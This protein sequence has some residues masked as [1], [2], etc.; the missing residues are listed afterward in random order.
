MSIK[1]D[2][3]LSEEALQIGADLR[4]EYKQIFNYLKDVNA[5][6]HQFLQEVA[7]D[8]QDGKAVFA[9]AFFARALTAF[10][11]L[12]ALAERGFL[13]ECRVIC[14]NLFEIK[15]RLGFL[16]NGKD[17]LVLFIAEHNRFKVKRLKAMRD[18]KIKL[19]NDLKQPNWDELITKT[20][21]TLKN[22]DGSDRRLPHVEKMAK[23]AGFESDYLGY[24]SFLSEAIHS[25]AGELEEYVS[26]GEKEEVIG[27]KYGPESGEWLAWITLC[28]A[29]ELIACL[30]I[31]ARIVETKISPIHRFLEQRKEEMLKRYYKLMT[32]G[33]SNA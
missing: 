1:D 26:F 16:E 4:A 19:G 18:G 25:G 20:D 5:K 8:N 14:R 30:H 23:E 21:A 3:F 2:G 28:A 12:I 29:S 27:F 13:S 31:T 9:V 17:A 32:L 33:I 15:F 10:Q 6:A 7:I 22:P 11:A 24:Y